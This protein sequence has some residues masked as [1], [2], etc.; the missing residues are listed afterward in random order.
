MD[1]VA[2]FGHVG[3]EAALEVAVAKARDFV[4]ESETEAGFQAPAQSKEAG[5]DGKF[6][7]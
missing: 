4:E 1:A 6:E 7:K 3:F 5:G 2:A